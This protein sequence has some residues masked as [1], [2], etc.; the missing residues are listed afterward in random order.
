MK[1]AKRNSASLTNLL[2]S[3]SDFIKSPTSISGIYLKKNDH[4]IGTLPILFPSQ[5]LRNIYVTIKL[6]CIYQ[7]RERVA[8]QLLATFCF[9][10][11]VQFPKHLY[12]RCSL[13]NFSLKSKPMASKLALYPWQLFHTCSSLVKGWNFSCSI[14]CSFC[15]FLPSYPKSALITFKLQ[16][17]KVLQHKVFYQNFVF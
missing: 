8:H 1:D 13:L 12:L 5:V 7:L 9:L 10:H 14:V 11:M 4:V 3:V 16:R 6:Y 17:L 15:H 2:V